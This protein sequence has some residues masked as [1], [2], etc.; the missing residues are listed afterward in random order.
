MRRLWE[1]A[2]N[3]E[4]AVKF[5]GA[6]PAARWGYIIK[7]AAAQVIQ[8]MGGDGS[9]PGFAAEYIVGVL[10]QSR[11]V[12]GACADLSCFW[13]DVSIGCC[14]K[15]FQMLDTHRRRLLKAR[16][17]APGAF[18]PNLRYSYSADGSLCQHR[19]PANFYADAGG[20]GPYVEVRG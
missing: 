19:V 2:G 17:F 20:T 8:L 15:V 9:Q 16:G 7:A 5:G 6:A 13:L 18:A 14:L 1:E 3:W 12:N 10:K 4:M 11:L